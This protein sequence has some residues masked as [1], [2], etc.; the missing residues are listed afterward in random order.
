MVLTAK[1]EMIMRSYKG[2]FF[3]TIQ[4]FLGFC[5]MDNNKSITRIQN[6]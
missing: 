4:L 3:S 6:F 2:L 5:G 1:N